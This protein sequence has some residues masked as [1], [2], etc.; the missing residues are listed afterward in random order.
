MTRLKADLALVLVELGLVAGLLVA[1]AVLLLVGVAVAAAEE[2][3][4]IVAK[5]DIVWV[6]PSI[7]SEEEKIAALKQAYALAGNSFSGG[8]MIDLTLPPPPKM[9]QVIPIVPTP[10]KR[11]SADL[12]QRHGMRKV[13]TG[14]SWR[15]RK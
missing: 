15:C 14:A 7:P 6:Y 12:C 2:G 11:A 8:P 5:D 9:V 10:E 4:S 3:T 1:T 13:I